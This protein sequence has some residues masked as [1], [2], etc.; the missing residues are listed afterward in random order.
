MFTRNLLLVFLALVTISLNAQK[1]LSK[2]AKIEFDATAKNSPERI[3]ASTTKAVLVLD[4]TTGAVDATM[5]IKTFHFEK[6]L[7]EEHFNE[8][9]MESDKYSKASFKGKIDPLSDLNLGKDGEQKIKIS[10]SLTIHGIGK[11][12]SNMATVT[13][14]GGKIVSVNSAFEVVLA[15]HGIKIPGAVQDKINPKAQVKISVSN[16]EVA[17]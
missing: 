12:V 10:G 5:L 9:Y 7:M 4:L 6:A 17:K 2:N 14:K 3:N 1:V 11:N 15:D 8:N 16:L 13:V